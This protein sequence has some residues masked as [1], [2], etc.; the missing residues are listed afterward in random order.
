MKYVSSS[1][2]KLMPTFD[3]GVYFPSHN[4][5]FG[6]ITEGCEHVTTIFEFPI[7][8]NPT[9]VGAPIISVIIYHASIEN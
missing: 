1:I 2:G 7:F 6:E 5:V 4:A 9:N 8:D 3:T